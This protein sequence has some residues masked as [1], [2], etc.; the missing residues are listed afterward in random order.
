MGSEEMIYQE[1][2]FG[3]SGL[4]LRLCGEYC[5]HLFLPNHLVFPTRK[6]HAGLTTAVEVAKLYC[7]HGG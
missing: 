1:L 5:R 4:V 7:I 3:V 2:G 6:M